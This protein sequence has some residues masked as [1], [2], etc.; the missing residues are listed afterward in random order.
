MLT[1]KQAMTPT[2]HY[3]APQQSIIEAETQ[4]QQGDLHGL[5]VID[6]QQH[7]LGVLSLHTIH[8]LAQDKRARSTVEDVMTRDPLTIQDNDTVDDALEQLTNH[9]IHWMPVIKTEPLSP[10]NTL[11]GILNA[12]DIITLYRSNLIKG[13]SQ[14]TGVIQQTV[15]NP[16]SDAQASTAV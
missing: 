9:R 10:E 11:I 12:N 3:L 2:L 8:D 5:P 13:A 16:A 14:L 15:T 6:Q 4:L 7:L 1:V